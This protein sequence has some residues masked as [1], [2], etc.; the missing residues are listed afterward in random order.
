MTRPRALPSSRSPASSSSSSLR[1]VLSLSDVAPP[2]PSGVV[3][4]GDTVT[5]L[6]HALRV[7][8]PRR[9][10]A[11]TFV[12][13][14]RRGARERDDARRTIRSRRNNVAESRAAPGNPRSVSLSPFPSRERADRA[15]RYDID[16]NLGPSCTDCRRPPPPPR[17]FLAHVVIG[18]RA[19][20]PSSN[21]APRQ[22]TL[23]PRRGRF[24]FERVGQSVRKLPRRSGRGE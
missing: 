11:R 7:R 3:N 9:G 15:R 6:R 22:R 24:E 1:A 14:R 12:A 23:P 4:F 16:T 18:A 8:A 21:A 19:R 20:P 10:T 2:N 5:H 13:P 17:P